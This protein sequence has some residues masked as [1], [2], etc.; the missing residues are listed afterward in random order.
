[1]PVLLIL[2]LLLDACMGRVRTAMSASRCKMLN[3]V[4]PV[5]WSPLQ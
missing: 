2:L 1:L 5:G 4:N 3:V